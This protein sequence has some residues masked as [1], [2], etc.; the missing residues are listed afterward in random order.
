MEEARRGSKKRKNYEKEKGVKKK[1]QSRKEEEKSEG[2]GAMKRRRQS[3]DGITRTDLPVWREA[4][5]RHVGAADGLYL[6]HV[7]EVALVQQLHQDTHTRQNYRVLLRQQHCVREC[8]QACDL[9]KV[10]DDVV[11]ET[12]TLHMLVNDLLLLVEGGEAGQRGEEDADTVVGLSVQL[13]QIHTHTRSTP[14]HTLTGHTCSTG[15][16]LP[17]RCGLSAGSAGRRGPAGC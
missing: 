15:K 4:R 7:L 1:T 5:R 16:R 12:E 11:E 10:G 13:L 9:I 2:K 6:L 17:R 3:A 8:L 14:E